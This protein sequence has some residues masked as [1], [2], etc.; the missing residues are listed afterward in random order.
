M[1]IL[2]LLLLACTAAFTG[3]VLA[4][5]LNGGP[6][7]N[8]TVLGHH[9]ATMDPLAIFCAGLALALIFSLGVGSIMNVPIAYRGRRLGIINIAHEAGWFRDQDA[10]AGRLIAA[11]LVPALLVD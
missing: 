4:D 1:L 6:D 9:I 8:V 3:F 2:G 10:A 7:Y 5:N 11:L